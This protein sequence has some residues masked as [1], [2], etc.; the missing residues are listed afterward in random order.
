MLGGAVL[1]LKDII[2]KQKELQ[3]LVDEHDYEFE[4]LDHLINSYMTA[5]SGEVAEVR[6]ETDWK[7]WK[8]K[9]GV[10][11]ENLKEEVADI[12]IFWL[13][14]IMRLEWSEE[15]WNVIHKKQL[16]NIERQKGK[17]KGKELYKA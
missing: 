1:E 2:E 6:N 10:N 8:K 9:E 13:D 3:V 17:V 5:I 7:W 4:D 14:M 11:K 12:F 16:K 15:I